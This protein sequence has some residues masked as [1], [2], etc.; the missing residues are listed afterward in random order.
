MRR[1]SRCMAL[2]RQMISERRLKEYKAWFNPDSS[3]FRQFSTNGIHSEIAEQD[4]RMTEEQALQKGYYRIFVGHEVN[5]DSWEHPNQRQFKTVQYLIEEN[6]YKKFD[7]TRWDIFTERGLWV[8][9]KLSFL[10]AEKLEDGKLKI[11]K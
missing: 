10:F 11:F 1:I 2:L 7:M 3:Y 5:I 8:F 6:S 4:L 9:P